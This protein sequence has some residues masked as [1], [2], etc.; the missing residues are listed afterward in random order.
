MSIYKQLLAE[1][2]ALDQKI[3]AVRKA[4]GATALAQIQEQ[5]A[6][7]GFTAQEVFPWK[8]PKAP[9]AAKFYDPSSG[10]TWSGRGRTPKWLADKDR[11]QFAIR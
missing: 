5:I 8:G 10:A 9:A 7:Y 2:Q 3:A 11:E 4:E 6:L 1:Q